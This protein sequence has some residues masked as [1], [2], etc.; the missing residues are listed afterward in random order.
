MTVKEILEKHPEWA[1]LPIV[2]QNNN[3]DFDYVGA[4]G[5][6]YSVCDPEEKNLRVLV[7]TGN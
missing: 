7:F 3:G 2:V 5:S 6:V 4:S 1:D